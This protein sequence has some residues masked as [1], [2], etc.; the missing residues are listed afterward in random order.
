MG[1]SRS[2]S[3]SRKKSSRRRS[4]S[5]SKHPGKKSRH[6][7][8]ERKS[9]KYRHRSDSSSNSSTNRYKS[10]SKYKSKRQKKRDSRSPS[11][12]RSRHRRRRTKSSDSSSRSSSSSSSSSSSTKHTHRSSSSSDKLH[13]NKPSS[14]Y[15]DRIRAMRTPT[16]PP[17]AKLNF[18]AGME[19][20]DKRQVSDALEEINA[21]DFQPKTFNSSANNKNEKSDAD[22]I[23][24]KGEIK[25]AKTDTNDDPL[26][27]QKL[28]RDDD[29]RM[30]EW[31]HR[32]YTYRQKMFGANN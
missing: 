11:S 2:R 32:F 20:L 17:A 4:S 12:H 27:H 30:K 22:I 5:R 10:S 21:N 1:R 25:G 31:V 7:T 14:S 3:L 13:R 23:K 19:F 16:P 28:F 8:P 29:E 6:H 18:D 15:V 24:L 26:F 9:S